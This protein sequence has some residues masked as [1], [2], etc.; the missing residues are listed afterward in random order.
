MQQHAT[1]K[2][3][4]LIPNDSL[5]P[6]RRDRGTPIHSMLASFSAAYFAGALVTDL[7]YWQMPDVMWERFSIWLIMAGLVMAGLAV[8]AYVINSLAGRGRRRGAAWPRLAG[9]AVAVCLAVINAFV[10]SRD[11]YTAVV[12]SGLMLSASVVAVLLLAEIAT[13]L[14]NRR[15]V[16][17]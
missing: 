17:G 3:A 4:T 6:V 15:R 1:I 5:R 16:G 2:A 14:A 8:F 9:Y 10:H 7:V 12:P 13:A 11:G